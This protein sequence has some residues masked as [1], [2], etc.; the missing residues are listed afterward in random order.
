[1]NIQ[2]SEEEGESLL[3]LLE[4]DLK[5]VRQESHRTDNFEFKE[6][7]RRKEGFLSSVIEKIFTARRSSVPVL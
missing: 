7:L 4:R 1:M 2:L 6:I 3:A 5:E